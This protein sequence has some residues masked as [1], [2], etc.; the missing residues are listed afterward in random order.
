MKLAR[1]YRHTQFP[2]PE[3]NELNSGFKERLLSCLSVV[4]VAAV[5][6]AGLS[7]CL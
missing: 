5:V 1:G 4:V 6:V 3:R 2:L 7:Q